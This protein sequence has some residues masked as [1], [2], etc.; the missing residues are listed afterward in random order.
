M[1]FSGL[2]E[3]QRNIFIHALN[4]ETNRKYVRLSVCVLRKPQPDTIWLGTTESAWHGAA[5]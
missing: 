1:S 4:R 2:I 5:S 3:I